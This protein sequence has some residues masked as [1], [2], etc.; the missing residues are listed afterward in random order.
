VPDSEFAQW[1]DSSQYTE[2]GLDSYQS[3]FGEHFV[4]PGGA[5]TAR[6]FIAALELSADSRVLDVCCGLGGSALLMAEE[7]GLRVDGVD[8]S[9]NMISRAR[10]T[11]SE[12]GLEDRV[13]LALG[14]CLE[15][16]RPGQYDAVYS[17]DAFMHIADRGRLFRV[18]HRCLKPGGRLL[19]TDYCCGSPPW[20]EEFC[21]YVEQRSYHLLTL[22][23]YQRILRDS[24]FQGVSSSDLSDRFIDIL[25]RE[26]R[27]IETLMP[28]LLEGEELKTSWLAKLKRAKSG[29][30]RWGLFQASKAHLDEPLS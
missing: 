17:R 12:R 19:F 5:E 15:L 1:L 26:L 2:Q 27:R 25:D 7:F 28:S 20:S 4:S 14:D 24:G 10:S 29:E 13:R 16:D 18:L 22:D 21:N 8:L 11:V 6:E 30:H 23:D 3:V 9:E